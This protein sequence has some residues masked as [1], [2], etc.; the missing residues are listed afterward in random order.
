MSK[1]N[2]SI[3][4]EHCIGCGLCI[5]ACPFGAITLRQRTAVIDYNKCTLCG[6]CA[7]VCKVP[8]AIKF[9]KARAQAHKPQGDVWVF[10]EHFEGIIA[11][12]SYELLGCGRQLADELHVGVSAILLGHNMQ[13]MAEQLIQHGADKVFIVTA[14]ALEHYCDEPYATVLADLIRKNNPEILLGGAT[15]VGRALLPRIAVLVHT[16]LTA[17]CTGLDI[18][19]ETRLLNQ[20]RPAFGGNIMA[21]ITCE[22][23]RPQMATVRPGVFP[24]PEPDLQRAG[25]IESI[26]PQSA[27]LS[28]ALT[29]LRSFK[30]DRGGED[31]REAEIIVAAGKGARDPQGVRLVSHLAAA[32]GGSLGASRAAVDADWIPYSHQIGQTG[33]TVQPQL[34]I[35]CG[36]SGAIQHLVGMQNSAK[37]IAVNH[38][39]EAPIFDY[40]DIAVVGDLHAILPRLLQELM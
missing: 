24:M 25:T 4:E 37:I 13:S 17:D 20:T 9:D 22:D 5:R 11:P 12:V 1:P 38:D 35:A 28:T 16:G 27:R 29:W 14:P 30:T 15:A 18:D 3:I 8:G 40:A 39:P 23:H 2:L 31:I 36:I 34:Y 21:T 7:S 26:S 32:L 19:P 33:T 6:A 10:C